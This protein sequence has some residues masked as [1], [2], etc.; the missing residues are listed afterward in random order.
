MA[1]D[2]AKALAPEAVNRVPALCNLVVDAEALEA[3]PREVLFKKL[4]AVHGVPSGGVLRS[5]SSLAGAI[6]L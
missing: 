3:A 4:P 1:G 5:S 6:L 2:V